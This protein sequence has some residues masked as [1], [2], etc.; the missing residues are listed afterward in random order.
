M[1]ETASAREDGPLLFRGPIRDDLRDAFSESED[2]S[3][4]PLKD[5]NDDGLELDG[6]MPSALTHKRT[7]FRTLKA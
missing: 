1:L 3:I 6:N 2:V 4:L 7:L 5:L